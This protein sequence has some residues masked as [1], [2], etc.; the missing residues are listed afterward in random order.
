M[1]SDF[2]ALALLLRTWKSLV[3]FFDSEIF[4]LNEGQSLPV[5]LFPSE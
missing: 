5:S 4:C 3:Q 2:E 1:N